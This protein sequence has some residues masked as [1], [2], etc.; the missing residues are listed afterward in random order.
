MKW[1]RC[2]TMNW[3]KWGRCGTMNSGRTTGRTSNQVCVYAFVCLY[4][5]VYA[6]AYV[7]VSSF[8]PGVFKGREKSEL[9]SRAGAEKILSSVRGQIF[10][11]ELACAR[12]QTHTGPGMRPSS[13]HY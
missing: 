4:V 9:A 8:C 13:R 7:G 10:I 2:G 3:G 11:L 6:Y 12:T 1:G 5:Y